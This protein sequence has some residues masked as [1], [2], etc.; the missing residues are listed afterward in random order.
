[1]AAVRKG[2]FDSPGTVFGPF[3]LR[4]PTDVMAITSLPADRGRSALPDTFQVAGTVPT[5]LCH[6]FSPLPSTL[7]SILPT[8]F[9]LPWGFVI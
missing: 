2:A 4:A 6:R 9:P 1:M 8:T 5:G 7:S 3:E